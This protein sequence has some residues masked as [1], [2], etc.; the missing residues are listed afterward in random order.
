MKDLLP[1]LRIMSQAAGD[2]GTPEQRESTLLRF[3][4]DLGLSVHPRLLKA[5]PEHVVRVL[6][7][8]WCKH[9]TAGVDREAILDWMAVAIVN[10]LGTPMRQTQGQQTANVVSLF[11]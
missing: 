11:G 2:S 9:I 10:P 4:E 8:Q 3:I 7:I 1:R 6:Y 5:Q